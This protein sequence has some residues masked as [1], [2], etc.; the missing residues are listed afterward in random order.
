M[1]DDKSQSPKLTSAMNQ[2]YFKYSSNNM[3]NKDSMIM[4]QKSGNDTIIQSNNTSLAHK[5]NS[6]VANSILSNKLAA[7]S[8]NS[9]RGSRNEDPATGQEAFENSY[10]LA[11]TQDNQPK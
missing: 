4:P 1:Y 6:R 9:K 2:K 10:N 5:E 11:G 3:K 8:L 7:G